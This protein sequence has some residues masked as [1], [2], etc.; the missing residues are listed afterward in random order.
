[1][2]KEAYMRYVWNLDSNTDVLPLIPK[3]SQTWELRHERDW[4][5]VIF[6]GA[7]RDRDLNDVLLNAP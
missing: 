4:E 5:K 7:W 6:R 1:M 2:C 3:Y